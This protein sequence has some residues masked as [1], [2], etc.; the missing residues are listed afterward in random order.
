MKKPNKE[1]ENNKKR[2]TWN[3]PK[4]SH[5]AFCERCLGYNGGICP[6][7]DPKNCNL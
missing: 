3:Y 6:S 1:Q 4:D 7:D 5:K 2:T